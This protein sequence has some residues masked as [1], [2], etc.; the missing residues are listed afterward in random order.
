VKLFVAAKY[1]DH[2]ERLGGLRPV[3]TKVTAECRVERHFVVK[4]EGELMENERILAPDE[5]TWLALILLDRDQG[6]H[7]KK[8]SSCYVCYIARSRR[9]P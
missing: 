2:K 3:V 7:L 6:V 8:T 4:I 5:S 1:L 9:G